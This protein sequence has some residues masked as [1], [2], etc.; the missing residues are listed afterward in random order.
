MSNANLLSTLQLIRR[1]GRITRRELGQHLGL[2]SSMISRLTADLLARGLICETGR[3]EAESGRPADF[4]SLNAQA[5]YAIGLEVSDAYQRVVIVNLAG[6]VV[7]RLEERASLLSSR[8]AI[9]NT[10]ASLTARAVERCSADHCPGLSPDAILGVGMGVWGVVDSE[11]GVVHSWTANVELTA[12]LKNYALS[13]ALRA[14]ADFQA[15]FYTAHV[16]VDDI[17][18]TL[19]L[20]EVLYGRSLWRDEDFVYALADTGIGLA[21][22]INGRA[23]IGP[24]HV[25]GEIGHVPIP[26]LTLPCHCGNIGCLETL[27]SAKG[28]LKRAAQKLGELGMPSALRAQSPLTIEQVI[29][30]AEKD[31]KLAYQLLNEAG[32][33]FGTGLAITVNLLGPRL[34]ILGGVLSKSNVYLDAARRS[35]KLHALSKAVGSVRIVVSQLDEFAGARGAAAQVLN[36]LFSSGEANLLTIEKNCYSDGAEHRLEGVRL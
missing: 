34:I 4:L 10:L 29:A 21:L 14:Q 3:S 15:V 32:E 33:V 31:D 6:E 12:A 30:A 19:G 8:D 23:Y 2:G 5:G 18:R 28:V 20:A 9:L 1:A 17:V 11:A 7:Y 25:A 13:A 26:G 22:M 36:I 24:S 16:T 27:A 35:M